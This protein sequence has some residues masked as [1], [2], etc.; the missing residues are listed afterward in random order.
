MD[1]V[2]HFLFTSNY[3][4]IHNQLSFIQKKNHHPYSLVFSSFS[5]PSICSDISTT[6]ILSVGRALSSGN[7]KVKRSCF[8]LLVPEKNNPPLHTIRLHPFI[9]TYELTI[10]FI[11]LFIFG[12]LFSR[13]LFTSNEAFESDKVDSQLQFSLE[14]YFFISLSIFSYF[15]NTSH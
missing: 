14:P 1:S 13:D 7:I 6:L 11:Y 5:D 12:S 2:C 8:I 9:H 10:F 4:V 3:L 15:S